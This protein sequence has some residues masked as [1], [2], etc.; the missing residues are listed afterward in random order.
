[1]SRR[2]IYRKRLE[3]NAR[4]AWAIALRKP[5][6][7]LLHIGKTGGTS[8]RD[9][10]W[11][12][13]CN[14]YLVRDHAHDFSLREVPR[15]QFAIFFLR[16]PLTRFTSAFYSRQRRGQPRYDFAW[17]EG[18]ALAFERFPSA[19]ALGEA[20]S[21]GH[22]DVEA[23][24]EAMRSIQH[25]NT[26]LGDWLGDPD[27][28]RSRADDLLFIGFQEQLESD[29]ARLLQILGIDPKTTRLPSDE[30]GAHRN[31]HHDS[32]LSATAAANLRSW[33]GRD[34]ELLAL[35]REL[36]SVLQAR[37]RS[38]GEDERPLRP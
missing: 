7:H 27:Y 3:R 37:Q 19:N 11:G 9:T 35:C 36:S 31:P 12:V 2:S 14:A 32:S 6:A 13:R 38:I 15:G 17:S 29:F 26:S 21:P 30:I 23:A 22:P 8:V 18:E 20:L 10:L 25:V 1:M 34:Y 33:Y 24:S 4:R 5:T 16:D 28:L